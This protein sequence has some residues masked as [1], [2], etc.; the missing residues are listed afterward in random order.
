MRRW[1]AKLGFWPRAWIAV[2]FLAM[3]IGAPYNSLSRTAQNRTLADQALKSCLDV[4]NEV[5]NWK[6]Q[7]RQPGAHLEYTGDMDRCKDHHQERYM[8]AGP[9][10]AEAGLGAVGWA[11]WAALALFAIQMLYYIGRWVWRGRKIDNQI[12]GNA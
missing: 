5:F 8:T 10:W 9:T 4:A 11:F 6:L 1:L 3:V 2:L 12:G 7:V